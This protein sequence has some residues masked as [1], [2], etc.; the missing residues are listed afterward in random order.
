MDARCVLALVLGPALA[1]DLGELGLQALLVRQRA[2]GV[3]GERA[4][5]EPGE[6]GLGHEGEKDL[7]CRSRMQRQPLAGGD[8]E[9][10]F[11]GALGAGRH[12]DAVTTTDRLPAG[13]PRRPG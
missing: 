3:A 9:R 4:R 1:A 5:E 13:P 11:A 8:G 6:L 2:A 12:E 7:A 10:G